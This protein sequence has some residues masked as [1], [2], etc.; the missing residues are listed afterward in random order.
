MYV[1]E[2]REHALLERAGALKVN[3]QELHLAYADNKARYR[4]EEPRIRASHILVAV[5]A[6]AT[7][8]AEA[9]STA[10][11]AYRAATTPGADFAALVR[12]FGTDP[13]VRRDGDLGIFE[14][15]TMVE[16]FASFTLDVGEISAPVRTKFGYHVIKVTGQ[17]A[18]GTLPFEA[19]KDELA[20]RLVQE[21][22][23]SG[24]EKLRT[25]LMDRYEIVDFVTQSL[26]QSS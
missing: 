4:S 5:P 21:K 10:M 7:S 20:R 24:R 25:T 16:E 23:T 11:Q 15:K 19:V 14:R 8:D 18:P 26:E 22:L 17:W 6:D 9:Q 12:K 13:S 1:A 2:L 3:E